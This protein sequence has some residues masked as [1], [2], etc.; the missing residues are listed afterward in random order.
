MLSPPSLATDWVL[1]EGAGKSESEDDFLVLSGV[2]RHKSPS[3]RQGS[4]ATPSGRLSL[5]LPLRRLSCLASQLDRLP[6]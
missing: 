2:D 5:C 1:I 3:G 4:T 6:G